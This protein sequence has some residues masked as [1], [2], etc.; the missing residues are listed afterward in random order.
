M[1]SE[2]TMTHW[3]WDL[4]EAPGWAVEAYQEGAIHV[5]CAVSPEDRSVGTFRATKLWTAVEAAR[6]QAW[7]KA[8]EERGIVVGTKEDAR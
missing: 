7:R 1:P 8:A 5:A 4:P 6:K 2:R 3:R